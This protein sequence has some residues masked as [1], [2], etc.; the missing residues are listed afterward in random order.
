[1][2]KVGWPKKAT[3]TL[4]EDRIVVLDKNGDQVLDTNLEDIE[5]IELSGMNRVLIL[6]V[7]G[8]FCGLDFTSIKRAAAFGAFGAVGALAGMTS[9]PSKNNAQMWKAT[10]EHLL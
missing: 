8:Q 4:Y 6:T 7:D 9:E 2:A 3:A 10:I 5:K 1:M